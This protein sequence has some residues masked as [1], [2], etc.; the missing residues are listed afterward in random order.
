MASYIPE[1]YESLPS[2]REA[3]NLFKETQA[4]ELLLGPI[5][6]LFLDS[7]IHEQYGVS[8]LHKHFPI[9]TNQ[10]LV[11]CR[12]I[13]TPWTVEN[14]NNSVVSKYEGFI[15]PRTFRFFNGILAPFEFDFSPCSSHGDPDRELFD[16][17]SALLHQHGLENV[18]G[19]RSLDRY[20][21]DLSVEITE[22]KTNI[23]I[24]RGSVKDSELIEA[25]WVFSADDDQRC[26]CR[27]YC[28]KDTKGKH[29]N[30]HGCS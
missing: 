20:D 6:E 25:L 11:D 29:L 26:H 27:E 22:G 17:I 4:K 23:M 12:N 5:R 9:E 19:V 16:R 1:A 18:L 10:R 30:D 13:S 8:L 7:G 24:P 3:A 14:S 2:L 21:P 28:W 15:I